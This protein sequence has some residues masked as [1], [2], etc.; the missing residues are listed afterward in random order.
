MASL[1]SREEYLKRCVRM[2]AHILKFD[3]GPSV[4]LSNLFVPLLG[5]SLIALHE[6]F[7]ACLGHS[8]VQRRPTGIPS[9]YGLSFLCAT[10]SACATCGT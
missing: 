5:L 8:R 6:Q 4:R 10:A 9:F 7:D 2:C 1:A 3:Y